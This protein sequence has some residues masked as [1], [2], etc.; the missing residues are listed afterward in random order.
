MLRDPIRRALISVSDKTGLVELVEALVDREIEILSTGGTAKELINSG[1]TVTEVSDYTGMPEIMDG[2]VQ[3]LHPKIYGGLLGI[4]GNKTHEGEMRDQNIFPIDLVVVNLYPFEERV[5]SGANF[6]TCIENVDIGGP[7]M[8]RAAS[9][10]HSD[11][12]VVVEP[13]DYSRLI[14]EINDNDGGTSIGFRRYL[15]AKAYAHTGTYDAAIS[16][17]L[18]GEIGEKYPEKVLFSGSL[19]EVLRYGE[20]PHQDAAFYTN[21]D[22][23]KGISTATMLQGK[24]LSF[25]NL[26]DSDAAFELVGEFSDVACAIIKHANPCGVAI[27]KTL[28][29]AYE[30]AVRCDL[31]SA[32][33]GVVAFNRT[34]DEETSALL[35]TKFAEVVIAPKVTSTAKEILKEKKNLRVLETGGLPDNSSERYDIRTLAGGY[36]IQGRDNIVKGKKFEIVTRRKPT[37]REL[38]DLIFAFTVCKHVKSNAIVYAKNGATVGI[39]AGQMSRVNSSRIAAWK[40]ADASSAAGESATRTIGSVLASDAFFPFADG[41]LAAAEAGITAVIQPGGS[42]RDKEVVEAANNAGLAM[43][44]TGI[45]HFRH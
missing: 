3:T 13:K 9:K 38:Y 34:L 1:I 31:E 25:N 43:V 42:I 23:Q 44:F 40:A 4:R 36:L 33:G 35:I 15:A 19:K 20:N 32:Y 17:W 37:D 24:E 39:G 22:T 2:R 16:S 45:R 10:N 11:V 26:N 8:I 21:G 28:L 5:K 12:V 6:Q 41:L 29:D 30:Q 18:F 7:A 27:A 14:K